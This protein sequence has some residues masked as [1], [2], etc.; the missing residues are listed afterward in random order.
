MELI[1]LRDVH[2]TYHL[3]E[4]NVPVLKGISLRHR[5]AANWWP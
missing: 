1:E 2:K 3:G 4:V 5:A